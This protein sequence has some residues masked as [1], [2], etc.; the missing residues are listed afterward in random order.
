[1][2]HRECL[3][4]WKTKEK[5]YITAG[6]E[7]GVDLHG[8]KLIIDESLYGLNTSAARFHEHLSES[9]LR[10]EFKKTKHDSDLWMVGK[11]SNYEYLATYVDDIIIWN[12]DPIAIIKS[13]EKTWMTLSFGARIL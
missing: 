12:K 11:S 3:L 2:W 4:I 8:K 6:P 13:L 9:L 1:M 5:V 10:L 7:S